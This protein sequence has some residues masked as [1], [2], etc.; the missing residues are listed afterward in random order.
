MHQGIVQITAKTLVYFQN[1]QLPLQLQLPQK[2]QGSLQLGEICMV[3]TD[4]SQ[5]SP[6]FEISKQPELNFC[7]NDQNSNVGTPE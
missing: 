1:H 2:H 4:P 3:S 6:K 5:V 7:L